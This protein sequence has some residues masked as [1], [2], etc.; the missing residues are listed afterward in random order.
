MVG[1]SKM[2]PPN[3]QVLRDISLSFFY[4]AKIGVLGLNG[5]GKS[6]LLGLLAG[7]DL[8]SEGRVWLGN[9]CITEMNEDGRAQIR[10]RFMSPSPARTAKGCAPTPPRSSRQRMGART[11]VQVGKRDSET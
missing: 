11:G 4:G 10:R 2:Y 5:S 3:K 6:T 1:V 8:P 9:A 7:L